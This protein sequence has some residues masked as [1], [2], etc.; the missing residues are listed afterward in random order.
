[1]PAPIFRIL[2]VDDDSTHQ[3]FVKE[4]VTS[5]GNDCL[6]LTN[7]DNFVVEAE[8]Y[9]PDLILLDLQMEYRGVFDPK[10]GKKL[11][12]IS[13]NNETLKH[14]PVIIISAEGNI[15]EQLKYIL[16]LK[17]DDYLIKPIKKDYLKKK[18]KEHARMGWINKEFKKANDEYRKIKEGRPWYE[19]FTI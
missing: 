11:L 3:D 7:T 15:R 9:N 10:A 16:S 14:I 13:K 2:S 18:I 19:R 6:C 12:E 8:R 4:T 1:M 5:M 17:C